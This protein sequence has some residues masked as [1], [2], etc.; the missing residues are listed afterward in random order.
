MRM[1]ENSCP[2]FL[3]SFQ[4]Q[5][6]G[7]TQCGDVWCIY[8]GAHRQRGAVSCKLNRQ[9]KPGCR[10]PMV[11]IIM[12]AFTG[13]LQRLLWSTSIYPRANIYEFMESVWQICGIFMTYWWHIVAMVS[14]IPSSQPLAVTVKPCRRDTLPVQLTMSLA[15]PTPGIP[16]DAKRC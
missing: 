11:H 16:A 15:Y 10:D 8:L 4:E 13:H 2:V 1:I 14:T 3:W 6:L 9:L 7:W 12:L 5:V